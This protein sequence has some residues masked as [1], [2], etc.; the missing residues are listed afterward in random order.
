MGRF[1]VMLTRCLSEYPKIL[2]EC[3]VA[4]RLRRLPGV[5]L[6]PTLFNTP[7]IYGPPA[8]RDA[9][10]SITREYI[11]IA[12]AA[13]LP[14]LL[15]APTWRLD[16][17]RVAAAGVPASINTDAVAYM[18]GLRDEAVAPGGPPVLVGALAGPRNDCYRPD[19]APG[20][21]EA[22]TF[23][24]AQIDELGTTP[25]AFLL[26]QT[27]PAVEEALGMARAMAK[28][29]KLYLIS[30]C[31]GPDGHVLDGTPLPDAMERIDAELGAEGKPTGFFVNCTH[32][33]FLLDAY[34][35]GALE[36]L[37]GIQ[38][39][40]SSRDVTQLDGSS[41]TLADPV[42]AWANDMLALHKQHGVRI[43]G[44][45]CG[46]NG[47]HLEA[48]A[49]VLDHGATPELPDAPRRGDGMRQPCKP[50]T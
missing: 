14:L 49:G 27:L 3:A 38:A 5:E 43:L 6:H 39:N 13:D 15:T 46:T 21:A 26:A 47:R 11:R 1:Q 22:E 40:A 29:G 7:L 12:R 41:A 28:T 31:T 32:P 50:E 35:V 36:R 34:P 10:A 25:A 24:A 20:A 18:I 16:A 9:M 17:E 48:L 45:C 42:E 37:V 33:R 30:F 19:L 8:A 44:G 4:E 2:A 23:H